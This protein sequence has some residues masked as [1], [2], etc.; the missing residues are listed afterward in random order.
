MALS[1]PAIIHIKDLKMK[2]ALKLIT[3]ISLASVLS[4]CVIAVG[5]HDDEYK[6]NEDWKK[7]QQFNQSY[8]NQLGLGAEASAVRKS[9]GAPALVE[10]FNKNGE[11]VEV[12]FYRTQHERSDGE[13]SKDECTPLVFKRGVLVGLGDK[14]Y[15]NL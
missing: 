10:L 8:I 7:I 4:G 9:L 2:T 5:D 14:A 15:Q 11:E 13:T 6:D 1:I 3:A 12:L